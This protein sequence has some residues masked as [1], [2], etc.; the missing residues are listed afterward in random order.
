MTGKDETPTMAVYVR[1]A[2]AMFLVRGGE[3]VKLGGNWRRMHI[4][5]REDGRVH[6]GRTLE[7]SGTHKSHIATYRRSI[8]ALAASAIGS[9]K[10]IFDL[11]HIPLF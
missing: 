9:G 2:K 8:P 10:G 5:T 6:M 3:V 7:S 11:G 4:R 1:D